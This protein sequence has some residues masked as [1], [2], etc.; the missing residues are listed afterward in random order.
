MLC[1][2]RHQTHVEQQERLFKVSN[3][4]ILEKITDFKK[5]MCFYE[6]DTKR[7]SLF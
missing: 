5:G 4:V 6:R 1:R 3:N 7:E 2:T